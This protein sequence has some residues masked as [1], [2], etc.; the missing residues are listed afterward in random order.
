[1][2]DPERYPPRSGRSFIVNPSLTEYLT[3]VLRKRRV[4]K[5]TRRHKEAIVR[6]A[7]ESAVDGT[8]KTIRL[9]MGYRKKL[10]RATE[11]CL[12]Y[13][14][15][16]IEAIPPAVEFSSRTFTSDPRVNA[17]FVNVD[18]LQAAFSH[19]SEMRDFLESHE[20]N[21]LTECC[22]LV[23][24][25]KTERNVSGMQLVGNMV[26]KDVPQ[27]TVNFSDY[28]INSPA[29]TEPETRKGLKNCLF[30]GVVT[31][32]LEG[33]SSSRY[34][35]KDLDRQKR[36]LQTRRKALETQDQGSE[37]AS[38]KHHRIEE[39]NK[40]LASIEERRKQTSLDGPEAGLEQLNQV[41]AH[42]EDFVRLTTTSLTLDRLGVKIDGDTDQKGHRIDLAE[43]EIGRS[44]R[45]V[46]VLAKFPTDEIRPRADFVKNAAQYLSLSL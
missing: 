41:L 13:V 3:G 28:E 44:N 4:E 15:D 33:L 40:K 1:M 42:P 27:T 30:E 14:D 10:W 35:Q 16:L 20:N 34:W 37:S 19:S 7:I 36:L 11:Y 32:A 12:D 43:V 9:V 39:I 31:S 25:K 17:F 6:E 24:M 46:V 5:T 26:Q 38:D 2:R 29:A 23:C 45:R 21:G 18:D 22:A 8:D